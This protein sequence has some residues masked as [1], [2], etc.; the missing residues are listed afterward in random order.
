MMTLIFPTQGNPIAVKRTLDS[1]KGIVDEIIIGS[2]C[3]FKDDEEL[4]KSYASNY[5]IKVIDFP[6]NYI[7][8]NGF[9]NTLNHLASFST[10]DN[11]IYLNVGEIIEKHD[12][13]ILSKFSQ[14]YNSYYIDHSQ[15]LH[16]WWRCYNRKELS[17]KGIIHEELGPDDNFRPYGKPLFTFADTDKDTIDPFKA[18]CMNDTKECVYWRQ[19]MQLVDCPELR[20]GVNEGWHKF[21]KDTYQSMVDRI[22]QKGNR[23][24][25]FIDGD[26]ESLMN[27]YYTNPEFEKERFESNHAIE[28]QGSP[29]YLGKK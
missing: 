15:E 5:N 6:F 10:N 18:K 14:E 13:N 20:E 1:T 3:L 11:I 19:L 21:A 24:N 12:G 22:K 16:R 4:I 29:M 26:Y 27:D 2:V 9:A 25:Y 8:I 7:F 28:F 23:F 17:W